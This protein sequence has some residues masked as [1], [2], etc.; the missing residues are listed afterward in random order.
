MILSLEDYG[1][2]GIFVPFF[3]GKIKSL[4]LNT[5]NQET[6]R[7]FRASEMQWMESGTS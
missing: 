7:V 2:E 1:L 6:E 4:E 5:R 3:V